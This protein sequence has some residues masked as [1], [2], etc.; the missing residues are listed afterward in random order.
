MGTYDYSREKNT[1]TFLEGLQKSPG[2]PI[3]KL[4]PE[5]ARNVISSVQA[6]PI[7]KPKADIEE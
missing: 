7:E 4:S 2:P 3:Y 5:Q 1:R 6:A